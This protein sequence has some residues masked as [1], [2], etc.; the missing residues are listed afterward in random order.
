[1]ILRNDGGVAFGTGVQLFD[2]AGR[3]VR[4]GVHLELSPEGLDRVRLGGVGRQE[5]GAHGSIAPPD[6]RPGGT[7]H[8]QAVPD[9]DHR[10]AELAPEP[11]E[12]AEQA[13]RDHVLVREE[14]KIKSRLASP[15]RD[16]DR[17]DHR[18]ALMG[19]PPLID[20]GRTA[21][22][23]PGAPDERG[24]EKAALVDK[25]DARSQPPGVFFT[26]GHSPRTHSR[27]ASSS[28]SRARRSGFWGLKPRECS[29]RPIWFA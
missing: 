4:E 8:V 11:A 26:R 22:R 12:K 1:M 2:V 24:H 23:R 10:G 7:M 14:A 27:M 18:D 3:M 19:T 20:D 28:R 5:N 29:R 15:A 21:D 17:R 6:P 16:G 13:A 25:D 9:D